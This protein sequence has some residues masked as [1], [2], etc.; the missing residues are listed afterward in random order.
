[1]NIS[2]SNDITTQ[3]ILSICGLKTDIVFLSDLRLNSEKQKSA[4]HDL[5]KKI[6]FNGYKI[7]HNSRSSSRG[8]G[9][10]IKKNIWEKI[11]ILTREDSDDCNLLLLH[12]QFN[13]NNLVLGAIYGPNRD[14]ELQFY[15]NLKNILK[16]YPEKKV[17]GGDWNA[18]FDQSPVEL[19]LDVLNMR[20][21]PSSIRSR[22]I[23]DLCN[24]CNLLE[25]FRTMYPN[26]K[27]YT[28]IPS[29]INDTNRSR[30]DFFLI[31][32]D[33]FGPGTNASIPHSLRST[34][35]DHKPIFLYLNSVKP[36]RRNIVKDTI[37]SNIDLPAYV[38]AA[39]YECL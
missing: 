20:N 10:L 36:V 9:I 38:R 33:I 39:V 17:I 37:L 18:T 13:N 26:K 15:D 28:F 14:N 32:R 12:V 34:L 3:K 8:V 35:F 21:I 19:N 1:M 7:L 2:T 6:F 5:E 11:T 16:N 30:L 24:E 31:S 27:E 23:H 25:P 29:G 22:K 4:V